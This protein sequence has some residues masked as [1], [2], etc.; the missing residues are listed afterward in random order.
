MRRIS[1]DPLPLP[2]RVELHRKSKKVSNYDEA[3]A[4]WDRFRSTVSAKKVVQV[5]QKMAGQR[6]HCVYCCDSR[7][8]DVDHFYPIA[9]DFQQAF[10]WKNLILICPECNRSKGS[11]C[12]V[13]DHGTPLLLNPTLCDPWSHLMLD[14]DTGVIAPRYI[15]DDFDPR[16]DYTLEIVSPINDEATIEGRR[17]SV[18][19]YMEV[20]NEALESGDTEKSRRALKKLVR[21]DEFGLAPWFAF[22]EGALLLALSSTKSDLPEYW[23][24][25]CSLACRQSNNT[26]L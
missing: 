2:S 5:L 25:F 16:G 8:A 12:K 21:Y 7:S 23:K 3:R 15:G 9:L 24:K 17:R 11:R 4:E 26:L 6:K 20:F 19:S 22:W 10:S 18:E 1:R 13:D 14:M